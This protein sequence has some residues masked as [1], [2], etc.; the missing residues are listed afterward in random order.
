M[1]M[2]FRLLI[3]LLAGFCCSALRAQLSPIAWPLGPGEATPSDKYEIYVSHGTAPEVRLDVL[4]SAAIAEGDFAASELTGRTFS[5]AWLSYRP[6]GAPLRFRVVKKFG[7]ASTEVQIAPRRLE[8]SPALSAPNEATFTVDA[9]ERYFSVHFVG[10]DNTTPVRRWIRHM[11]C[12]FIDPPETARPGRTDA[13]VVAFSPAVP[14]ATLAAAN[15]LYFPA[16]YHNLHAYPGGGPIADGILKLRSGQSV[17]LAAGAFVEGLI[18]T[19]ATSDSNQRVSGRGILT[20]RL[21]PWYEKPGY[22]GP[23]YAQILRLGNNRAVVEGIMLMESPSHG[24]VGWQANISRLKFLGWHSNN[25]AI[26]VGSGSEIGH[27]FIRAVDD[28]FYNFDIWVHD[29]VLW[30]GHNGAILTYGWGGDN[31]ESTYNSGSSLLEHIDIIHP[32]W[33]GLGNNNGLVAAQTGFDYKPFGYGGSTQTVL[34]HIRIEGTIPGLLNLKPRSASNGTVVAVPVAPNRVGYLGD[35]LLADI[36]VDAQS[37]RSRLRGGLNPAGPGS[38]PYFVQDVEFRHVRIAG[39]AVT[40]ANAATHLDI[41]AATTRNL[42]F[43]PPPLEP[44][45]LTATLNTAGEVTLAWT[46][47]S[48]DETAFVIQR[49][50]SPT[51]PWVS[52]P[53]VPPNR[54]TALDRAL[55]GGTAYH[56]RVRAENESGA[57]DWTATTTVAVPPRAGGLARLVNASCRLRVDSGETIIPGFVVSGSAPLRVLLRAVGP[58]LSAFLVGAMPDPQMELVGNGSTL[59]SNDNWTPELAAIAASV[60]AFPLAPGTLDAALVATATPGVN[61]SVVVQGRGPAANAGGIVL[62]EVYVLDTPSATAS[63]GN[64]SIRARTGPGDRTLIVG[65]VLEGALSRSLLV[66][67]LGPAL[68]P[69]GLLDG[70]PD[71]RLNVLDRNAQAIAFDDNWSA[72]SGLARTFTSVGAFPLAPASA[73]AALFLALDSGSY[74]VQITDPDHRSGTSLLELYLAP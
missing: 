66:R 14:G 36:T 26:R 37:S 8:F 2:I 52:L 4:M 68:R 53:S 18:D 12:I 39:Q 25:D 15:T 65:F 27:C 46:D 35:L 57:S 5:F 49:A 6:D 33:F 32:E 64:L 11:L 48:S 42:R 70:V 16:G 1:R 61:Y 28:H 59:A 30:A 41:E 7:T 47:A 20:G 19:Q 56:Y 73:D 74:T 40:A 29:C 3:G 72:A 55:P 23:R 67:G 34:R 58:S 24:I 69:F 45:A 60:G 54:A 43:F 63:L 9:T 50:L 10:L 51:G 44:R 38:A 21:F 22:T 62:V 71:P 31:T 13:G 17:Y